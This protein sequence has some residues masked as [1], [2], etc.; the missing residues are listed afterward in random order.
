MEEKPGTLW[1]VTASG[2]SVFD[3]RNWMSYTAK[4]S[5]FAGFIPASMVIDRAGN[6]WIGTEN[7]GLFKLD[8]LS[9]WTRFTRENSGLIDNKITALA[10]DQGGTLWI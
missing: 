6:K 9:G 4:N 3:G 5:P 10:L 7:G 8:A 2:V 1:F